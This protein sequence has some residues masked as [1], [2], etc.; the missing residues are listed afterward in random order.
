MKFARIFVSSVMM[1]AILCF[2]LFAS[3]Q[4]LKIE[5][6]YRLN[7]EYTGLK[8]YSENDQIARIYGK[9]FGYCSSPVATAEQFRENHAEVYGVKSENLRPVSVL[10][11]GRHTQP[12]M[13]NR[14]TGDYKFN[15]VYYTQY[16]GDIPVFRSD[17]RLLVLNK[18]NYP[19]VLAASSLKDLAEFTA[20]VLASVNENLAYGAA[21]SFNSE[22]ANISDPRLVV[23]A[24]Y[25]E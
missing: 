15:L 24:G 25:G 8:V 20:P 12:V 18:A 7:A 21:R 13:Y 2:P 17:L 16:S 1:V 4:S 6:I 19:L 5:A 22:L 10:Y 23:W 11:D 9:P 3:E 14:D